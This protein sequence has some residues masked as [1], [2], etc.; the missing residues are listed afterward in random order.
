M[1]SQILR[2][3]L[4]LFVSHSIW[5]YGINQIDTIFII[6]SEPRLRCARICSVESSNTHCYYIECGEQLVFDAFPSER[7][8]PTKADG[9]YK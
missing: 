4:G 6:S 8:A 2:L 3:W 1:L 5:W 9:S 7:R